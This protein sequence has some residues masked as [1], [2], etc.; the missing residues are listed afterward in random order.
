MRKIINSTY[1]SLDGVI[2]DPQDWPDTGSDPESLTIQTDLLFACDTLIMG[3][4][5][6][7]S[8]AAVWPTR[9]GDPYSGRINSMRKY[10]VSSTLADPE[11]TNTTAISGDPVAALRKLKEQPGQDILQY[12]FGELSHTMLRH[13]LLDELRLWIHPLFVGAGGPTGLIFREGSAA[14]LRLADTKILKNGHIVASYQ[15]QD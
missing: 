1:V 3:R 10:V 5:T 4:R 6:Y 2:A 11:W 7:D 8:F 14:R 12:G 9:S 13:G 15:T